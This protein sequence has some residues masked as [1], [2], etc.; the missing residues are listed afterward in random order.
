MLLSN[1]A[2]NMAKDKEIDEVK[3][4]VKDCKTIKINGLTVHFEKVA[5]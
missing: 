1:K 5:Q 3:Y 2:I 4:F